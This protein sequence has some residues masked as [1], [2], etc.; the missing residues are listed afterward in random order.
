MHRCRP[1]GV[2]RDANA[3]QP[4]DAKSLSA[5]AGATW[6]HGEAHV[7]VAGWASGVRPDH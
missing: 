4:L 2:I 5:K 3:F 7:T 6:E 1:I